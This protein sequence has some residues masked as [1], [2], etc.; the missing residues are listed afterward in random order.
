MKTNKILICLLMALPTLLLT[1]CLKDQSDTF[2]GAS[3]NRVQ[4]YLNETKQVLI[5]SEQG[6]AFEY[7]PDRQQS[8]GGYQYTVRFTEDSVYARTEMADAAKE[9][10][11][12]YKMGTDNG[13]I[14]SFDTYNEALHYFATPSSQLYEAY[15]GDFEFIILN[16]SE[17]KNTIT[18]KGKRSGTL[19]YMRRLNK[20]AEEYLTN[21]QTCMD[22]LQLSTAVG[23]VG[24]DSIAM[25]LDYDSRQVT[26]QYFTAGAA[27]DEEPEEATSA[28]IYTENGIRLYSPLKFG[29]DYEISE[30]TG[31][32]E[33]NQLNT[34]VA[35]QPLTLQLQKPIGWMSY[36]E[37]AGTYEL[38]GKGRNVVVTPNADGKTFIIS[39][40]GRWESQNFSFPIKATYNP[41]FGSLNISPQM[42]G[43]A[44][45]YGI[46][47]I[48]FDGD[49]L[50]Y[51]AS[52][53]F[54]GVNS[55]DKNG[56]FTITFRNSAWTTLWL[57][58]FED[59]SEQPDWDNYAG[60]IE[61]QADVMKLVKIEE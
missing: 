29:N 31:N 35:G 18:L 36:E 55:Y 57:G 51:D 37:L 45:P 24:E 52:I 27:E 33:T 20:D 23:K 10:A 32:F 46:W 49:Y 30:F 13:P 53:V 1:S 4:D 6:W 48:A 58:A 25:N 17:D 56:K 22:S 54:K 42:V 28:F 7:Y 39:N 38:A 14:L 47:F 60:R 26:L 43:T 9:Y 41:A 40:F 50:A 16:I 5:S 2:D 11:S 44:G 59:Q 15:D 12:L 21:V 61:E 8:Y 3:A 34:S 19:S